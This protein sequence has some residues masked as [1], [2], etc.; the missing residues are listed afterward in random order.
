M[1]SNRRILVTG[2]SGKI[3]G[4]IAEL[5]TLQDVSL[6]LVARSLG[7]LGRFPDAERV[8]ADYADTASLDRAFDGVHKAFVVS[9]SEEPM[10]RAL[11]HRN[12]F[13]AAKR[14]GV[15]YLVYLSFLGASPT[16]LFPMSRD[17]FESQKYLAETGIPFTALQDSFYAELATEMF[18]EDG[19]MRGPAGD[20]KVSWVGRDEVAEAIVHLVLSDTPRLGTVPST[21]AKAYSMAETAEVLTRV[22]GHPH[23]Y[24]QES[25]ADARAARAPLATKPWEVDVWVGSYQ[26]IAAGE[27]STV[28]P[29]LEDLLGRP[30]S[31]LET[32][33]KKK[34]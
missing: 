5:L 9:G 1:S 3:G 15:S 20:G 10:K 4:K 16:S 2:A 11:L 14:A 19:L 17:H 25:I 13:E 30:A 24:E 28:T 29:D 22:S 23:R 32:Y 6:R 31:D 27:V 33:L 34:S 8:Q 21:G 7:K 12:A 18:N 26:A